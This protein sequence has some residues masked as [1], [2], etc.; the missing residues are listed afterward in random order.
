MRCDEVRAL[1]PGHVD[2]G[3][4]AADDVDVHL[5]GCAECRAELGS[6]RDLLVRLAALRD[7]EPEPPA[8]LVQ[9]V[10][11]VAPSA[12]PATRVLG[13]V[14]AHPVAYAM[15]GGMAVGATAVALMWRRRRQRAAV[16]T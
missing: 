2:G 12:S 7:E 1:L 10:L 5:A 16:A 9:G 3:L 8:A 14:Q 13:S 6:Y 15:A 11:A 4:R